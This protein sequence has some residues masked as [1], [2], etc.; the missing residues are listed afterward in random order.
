MKPF[1][2]CIKSSFTAV[3]AG[4]A[5]SG[6]VGLL[7]DLIVVSGSVTEPPLQRRLRSEGVHFHYEL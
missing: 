4:L 7:V 3:I 6:K 1:D 5:G 2:G